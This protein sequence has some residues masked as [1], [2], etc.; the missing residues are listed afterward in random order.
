MSKSTYQ[1]A[2]SRLESTAAAAGTSPEVVES[3]RHPKSI[4]STTLSVRMD[5]GRMRY[6]PA[7]RCHYNNIL[8][9]SKGGIRFHPAVD[10]DEVTA[11]ALWMTIK[12]AV[13]GLPYGGGKGGV[14]VDPKRLTPMELERLSRH[15]MRSM[16]DFIG[17]ELDIPAP[18]VNTN[19]R[20]MGW[21][22]SEYEVIHKRRTPA[23]ITGKPI[24]L[25]GSEG[26]EEAT[27]RGA[28]HCVE[29]LLKRIGRNA[30]EMTVAIQGF[31]NAGQHIAQLLQDVGCTIVAISDS[32]GGI[33]SSSGFDTYSIAR[34]KER[35]RIVRGVYC[36]K[37][38]CEA[39]PHEQIS[40]EELLALDV[41]L[42]I[43]A[44]LDGVIHRGNADSVRAD[45][46][47]EVANGPVRADAEDILMNK[48]VVIVPDV[49]V[50]AGGVTV[51][52][53]E[54]VQNRQGYPWDLSTVRSRLE[55]HMITAFDEV[56]NEAE[57]RRCTLRDAAYAL[58]LRRIELS[59]KSLGTQEYFQN[60]E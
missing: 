3:L 24:C 12:C 30:S 11:L 22:L 57:Q 17:P 55:S 54:W 14:Q 9:P 20:I 45:Y 43:P 28:F 35:S 36:D 38:V 56:W 1:D 60:G 32:R 26:R 16:A 44:A 10:Q 5:D 23:V 4:L 33:Y 18:D 58:A 6:F 46:I 27:G 8:G 2:L 50:N 51:S 37:S 40:N 7:Y 49:L 19:A 15:Y 53:F 21:M 34:E 48:G 29:A 25:G 41:D 47:L 52:Y 59:M 13:L 39:V 31:G 42:L